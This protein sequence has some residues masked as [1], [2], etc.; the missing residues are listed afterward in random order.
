MLTKRITLNL[1]KGPINID[2]QYSKPSLTV[3]LQDGIPDQGEN[4]EKGNKY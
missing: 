3:H 2:F 4:D 1:I